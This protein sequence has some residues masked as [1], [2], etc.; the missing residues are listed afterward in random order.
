MQ[1]RTFFRGLLAGFG[2]VVATPLLGATRRSVLIQESPVA[3][4]QFHRGE[5][6]WSSLNVGEKLTLVREPTNPHD[7]DAVAVYFQDHKLGYVPRSENRA[8]AQMLDRGERLEARISELTTIED[9]WQRIRFKI[10]LV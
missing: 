1:R 7:E 2:A 4:F 9:P 3:G 10:V 5:S 6:I 8:V